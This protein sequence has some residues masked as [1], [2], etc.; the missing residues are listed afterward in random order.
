MKGERHLDC[1]LEE[2]G[3]GRGSYLRYTHFE[4]SLEVRR[5]VK[6][7]RKVDLFLRKNTKQ[8][9]QYFRTLTDLIEHQ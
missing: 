1:M 3:F 9:G 2:W 8:F 4:K 7:N 5:P 6:V